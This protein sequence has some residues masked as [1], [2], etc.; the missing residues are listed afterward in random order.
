MTIKNYIDEFAEFDE[1]QLNSKS[2]SN[3]NVGSQADAATTR[4]IIE[5]I[6]YVDHEANNNEDLLLQLEEEKSKNDKLTQE[7]AA[8]KTNLNR[9]E[10]HLE[11]VKKLNHKLDQELQLTQIQI[12]N[13]K[14][15]NIKLIRTINNFQSYRNYFANLL[16]KK[17]RTTARIQRLIKEIKNMQNII[18]AKNNIIARRNHNYD[19]V[20]RQATRIIKDSYSV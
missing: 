11:N 18:K 14:N 10:S 16:A 3:V 5:S 19:L 8:A 15:I 13:L 2:H 20:M 6:A 4:P 17:Q 7:L 12:K 1:F 9:S